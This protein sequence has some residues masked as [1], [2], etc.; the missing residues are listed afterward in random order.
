MRD[1]IT[2]IDVGSSK[3]CVMIA[4]LDERDQPQIIGIG[5]SQCEGVKKG[6]VV[7]IEETAKSIQEA[8]EKAESMAN[9]SIKS[10]HVALPGGYCEVIRNKG[11]IAVSGSNR[12]IGDED[13][14]RVIGAATIISVSQNSQII[15]VV[16]REYVVDGYDEIRDPMG[17]TGVRLE[18][19]ADIV[20]GS[21]TTVYNLMKAVNHAS[22]EVE[23]VVMEPFAIAESV[24]SKDEKELG[25]LLIDVGAGK[26]DVSIFKNGN[27]IFSHLIPVGGWHI[28]HDIKVGLRTSFEESEQL[29][30]KHASL[31]TSKESKET[32]TIH[33]LGEQGKHNIAVQDLSGIVY[34]RIEEMISIIDTELTKKNLKK[35]LLTGAVITGGGLNYIAGVTELA[36]QVLGVNVRLGKPEKIGAKEP[37]FSTAAGILQY[38]MKRDFTYSP[39]FEVQELSRRSGN[40]KNVRNKKGIIETI[41]AFW[42]STIN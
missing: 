41:K 9:V 31:V 5:K 25:V 19:D 14:E 17:M 3:V 28:S 32:I 34:A 13:I 27:L 35:E 42:N 22:L 30:V 15:D 16:P 1:I 11:M 36:R 23:S 40:H 37:I 21:K 39:D 38:I 18:V 29:K 7:D 8:V 24:L 4:E 6:V 12:E 33:S 26:T 20:V 10:A 2:S